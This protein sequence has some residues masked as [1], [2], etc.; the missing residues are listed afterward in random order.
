MPPAHRHYSVYLL[1]NQPNGTLYVGVTSS[2]ENRMWQ[3]KTG[4]FEGFS[5]RY[6]LTRLVYYEDYRDVK[7]AIAREKEL[8][9][10]LRAKKVDLILK[11]N[12]LWRDLAED[13][14]DAN[15]VRAARAANVRDPGLSS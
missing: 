3:H 9:G 8:K 11:E 6:G 4:V 14:F 15:V 2:L 5:K 1:S 12:P 13:W 10:W 7:K